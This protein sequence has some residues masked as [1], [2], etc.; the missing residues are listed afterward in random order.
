MACVVGSLLNR[1]LLQPGVPGGPIWPG[2]MA[3]A[4]LAGKV[5]GLGS[6]RLCLVSVAV[7][8][9]KEMKASVCVEGEG[10]VLSELGEMSWFWS[11]K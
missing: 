10:F 5:K 8:L 6:V 9:A 4:C 11:L 3:D 1:L 7:L 2:L